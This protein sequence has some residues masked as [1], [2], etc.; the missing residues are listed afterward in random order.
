MRIIKIPTYVMASNCFLLCGKEKAAVIDPSAKLEYITDALAE[1]KV[2]LAYILL[3]HGHFDHT[4]NIKTL[5]GLTG[6]PVCIHREDN[7]MLTDS[8]KNCFSLFNA[9][10][11]IAEDA[12]LLLEDG[13][14]VDL[15]GRPIKVLHTPGHSKGSVCYMTG[16]VIFTGDTLL[17]GTI[18]RYDF[19]GSD[20]NA[21]F[22][23]LRRLFAL[24]GDL[25]VYPG[26]GE[27]TSLERERKYNPFINDIYR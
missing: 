24:P 3:T 27:K 7:E 4:K 25:T 1:E 21:L 6:A 9:G 17:A 15:E 14:T 12:D 16:D 11:Q 10:E 13:D 2:S 18:G 26:H 8:V 22:A 19:Y 23:S 5:H 20:E